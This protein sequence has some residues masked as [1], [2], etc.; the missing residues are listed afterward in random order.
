VKTVVLGCTHFPLLLPMLSE[1]AGERASEVRFIDPAQAVACEV[2]QLFPHH[3]N[4]RRS[5]DDHF[6]ISGAQDGVRGWIEKL[7]DN[8]APQIE[9]G[10]VFTPSADQPENNE[11]TKGL[12]HAAFG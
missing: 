9:S 10:P 4:V 12:V 7:L 2:T 8:A 1:V 5:D 11:E 3:A 6:F